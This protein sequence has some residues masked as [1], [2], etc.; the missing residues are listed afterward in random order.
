MKPRFIMYTDGSGRDID[1]YG[2]CSVFVQD[3]MTKKL[4]RGFLAMNQTRVS[5]MEM[6]AG[7]IGLRII[8]DIMDV[9][10]P[11]RVKLYTEIGIPVLW[12]SD[13]ED[14]TRSIRTE[15]TG[16]KRRKNGDLWASLE[17]FEQ[18]LDIDV[19]HVPRNTLPHQAL[20]DRVAGRMRELIKAY[21][22]KYPESDESGPAHYKP[23]LK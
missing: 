23:K 6:Q 2:G 19:R 4:H 15:E 21:V 7:L 22:K 5:R 8:A 9:V 3:T 16:Y 20:A 11:S 13:R 12:Y 14:M 1:G 10:K 17:Y 18:F